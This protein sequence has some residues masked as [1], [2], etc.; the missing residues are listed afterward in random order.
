MPLFAPRKKYTYPFD[1]ERS[2]MPTID[3]Q[4]GLDAATARRRGG[5]DV[6][7]PTSALLDTGAHRT[8]IDPQSVDRLNLKPVTRR[9]VR[10][11]L[12]PQGMAVWIV[13]VGVQILGRVGAGHRVIAEVPSLP[14]A[15][16]HVPAEAMTN[17][18]A[19]SV[20]VGRDVLGLLR[21][22]YLGDKR[23]IHM[24]LSGMMRNDGV[25]MRRRG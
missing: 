12:L 6:L 16:T 10:S 18:G 14:V 4:V 8:F 9:F 20:I 7:H 3:V 21:F 15:I 11:P 2:K 5:A 24:Y 19:P 1:D 13:P 25:E 17:Q 22:D 23:L